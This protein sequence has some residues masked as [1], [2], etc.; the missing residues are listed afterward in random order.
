MSR[1]VPVSVIE[2]PG[3][4]ITGAWQTAQVKALTDFIT[5]VPVFYGYQTST[6]VATSGSYI[7]ITLDTEVFDSDNGHSTT[8]NPSR[9]T[10]QV[11]GIYMAI[12]TSAWQ[13]GGVGYRRTRVT[14]NGVTIKGGGTG[15]DTSQSVIQGGMAIGIAACNGTTDYFEVQAAQ[16][17]G[18]N[19]NTASSGEF[20]PSLVVLWLRS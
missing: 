6:Q 18:G 3:Q 17:T 12:G 20:T 15:F 8:V 7:S 10:P 4:Y 9:Y 2:N 5:A 16:S 14:L 1:I 19:L 13:S 11:P